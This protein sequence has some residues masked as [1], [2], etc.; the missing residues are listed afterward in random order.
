MVVTIKEI[1]I[2]EFMIIAFSLL[3]ADYT[4]YSIFA[5][6]TSPGPGGHKWL[7]IPPNEELK[8]WI[9]TEQNTHS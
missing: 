2:R 9:A 7:P 8:I 4:V 1:M 3:S 5:Y 6:T